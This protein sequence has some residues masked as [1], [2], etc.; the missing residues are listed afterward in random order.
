M[1]SQHHILSYLHVMTYL[2]D[3]QNVSTSLCILQYETSLKIKISNLGHD[4]LSGL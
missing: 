1:S 3:F 4:L 2:F